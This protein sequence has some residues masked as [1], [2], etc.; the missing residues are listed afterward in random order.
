MVCQ[1]LNVHGTAEI[2]DLA[3]LRQVIERA[4]T[5]LRQSRI[6]AATARQLQT[7]GGDP[8]AQ[9]GRLVRMLNREAMRTALQCAER[10]GWLV[11]GALASDAVGS[12]ALVSGAVESGSAMDSVPN[13]VLT[14]GREAQA[15][16]AA[17]AVLT[18]GHEA[19][20]GRDRPP[21]PTL[22]W[23][24]E[25]VAKP[26]A[27]AVAEPVVKPVTEPGAEPLA[28][29]P[30]P[31][32]NP[33]AVST[34]SATGPQ[35]ATKS[36]L[37]NATAGPDVGTSP[38]AIATGFTSELRSRPHHPLPA[39]SFR[40]RATAAPDA[41]IPI[42]PAPPPAA[43]PPKPSYR[44]PA[45]S[46]IQSN[47]GEVDIQALMALANAGESRAELLDATT[48]EL[49]IFS[50]VSAIFEETQ[51]TRMRAKP[52]SWEE[53][54]RIVGSTLR[55]ARRA[56]GLS[57]EALHARTYIPLQHLTAIE[58]GDPGSLPAPVY[59][60]GFVRR[61]AEALMLDSAFL[62]K[63]LEAVGD[64]PDLPR[65]LTAKSRPTYML[66]PWHA[67]VGYAALVA[68]GIG[69]ISHSGSET[70]PLEPLTPTI[71]NEPTLPEVVP[72]RQTAPNPEPPETSIA[73]PESF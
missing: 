63:Q 52:K 11:S 23:V 41:R 56:Q 30:S 8:A 60:R 37:T 57:I 73:P 47:S 25:P 4:E 27:E 67:Y 12:D 2:H 10:S 72:D 53:Q 48:E 24:A 18:S 17:D 9:L 42:P 38:E 71:L 68:G 22:A 5:Q 15:D 19:Q 32:P 20:T 31:L 43:V 64:R 59:V 33:P 21:N 66:Q 1:P 14:S 35:T 36:L 58:R 39:K 16:S 13:Q 44:L 65:W 54:L 62:L 7:M 3:A 28:P 55:H 49:N 46:P 70:Q 61:M 34:N 45:A 51:A 29:P 6:Y 40:P 69:F 26:V 50:G